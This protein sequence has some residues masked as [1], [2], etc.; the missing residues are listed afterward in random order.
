MSHFQGME[1][2]LKDFLTE[3]G[4]LLSDVD[5]KLMELEQRPNDKELLNTIFRGFHTI[6]G[7]AG[8]LNVTDLVN[9]CHLTE[10]LF[11][12]LRNSEL[13]L[14][15]ELMDV[16]MSATGCV[17]DMF[18]PLRSSQ[19][20]A[21]ADPGLIAAM[22]AALEG[23]TAAPQPA[24]AAQPAPPVA[25]ETPKASTQDAAGVDWQHWQNTILGQPSPATAPAAPIA[26][27]NAGAPA[28]AAEAAAPA[29]SPGRRA[30]DQPDRDGARTELRE[31]DKVAVAAAESTIRVGTVRLDQV[32]NLS[33]EIG[34]AKN[35]LNCLRTDLLQ[36]KRDPETLR[37]LDLAVSRLDLLVSD[38]QNAVM[39]TRMQPIWRLFQKYPRMARDLSRQLGKNIEV[40]LKGEETELDKTM[41]ED[42]GDPLIHLVRNAVDHGIE[43]PADRVAQGKPE[44]SILRLKAQQIGDS[45]II[46][47]SD[48]GRGMRPDIIRKKAVEKGCITADAAANLNDDESLKLILLPGFSTKDTVSDVSGRGVGMA[49]VKT[50]IQK[51]NGRI[52]IK[53]V[54]GQGSTFTIY[55]PLT[56]AILPVLVVRCGERPFAVPLAL[57]REIIPIHSEEVQ[58]ISGKATMVI[59]DEILPVF[60]LASLIGWPRTQAPAYGV[61]MQSAV[62]SF[63]LAVDS[64]VG[65][66]DVVIK[67]LED[68]KP[69]GVAGATQSGDGSVVLV[70]DMEELLREMAS[71]SRGDLLKAAA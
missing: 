67:P 33:G 23:K 60:S 53:S 4:E 10:N 70:L 40:A 19:L 34:L 58:A 5:S 66:D 15:A 20:P 29:R 54:I 57:V 46:E 8:F 50:K 69:R 27:E 61:L 2:L 11:D 16:I 28:A 62:R 47:I 39:K 52:E 9:L 68:I 71:E 6:K 1:E 18:G 65:R 44:K 24:P 25:A 42:L 45:I 21:P 55:L 51:L 37:E 59:R 64:F 14:N 17:S 43:S 26:P 13:L 3:A 56:L 7:G 30:T 31:N 32:L 22:K 63:I 49:V 41:I 48:D 38:L 36:G 35:R 12:K